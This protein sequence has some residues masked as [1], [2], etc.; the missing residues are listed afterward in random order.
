M[1]EKTLWR[2][3]KNA[4][5]FDNSMVDDKIGFVFRIIISYLEFTRNDFQSELGYLNYGVSKFLNYVLE[6]AKKFEVDTYIPTNVL[7]FAVKWLQTQF[8]I[9]W[10][11]FGKCLRR[12]I[13]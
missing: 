10:L 3:K 6:S 13:P 7:N 11:K 4:K 8:T 9:D 5:W 2:E 12:T 1:R